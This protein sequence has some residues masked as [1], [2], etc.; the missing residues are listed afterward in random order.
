MDWLCVDNVWFGSNII[1]LWFVEWS[2]VAGAGG[3]V[4]RGGS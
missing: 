4:A 2:V 1:R 3:D